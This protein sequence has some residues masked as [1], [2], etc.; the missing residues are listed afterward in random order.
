MRC[1][2]RTQCYSESQTKRISFC[3][4]SSC[5]ER[6]AHR[7][8]DGISFQQHPCPQE[9][10]VLHERDWTVKS[11][12]ALPLNIFHTFSIF[13]LFFH[14]FLLTQFSFW[15]LQKNPTKPHHTPTSR[16]VALNTQ[17]AYA[18]SNNTFYKPRPQSC[19]M[20][21]RISRYNY[22]SSLLTRMSLRIFFPKKY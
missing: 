8:S 3:A 16:P 21:Y 5:W 14:Y 4:K 12:W 15:E 9:K 17:V 6:S 20:Q 19:L 11:T 1:C 10:P 18:A 2:G 13:M 7:Q 22:N